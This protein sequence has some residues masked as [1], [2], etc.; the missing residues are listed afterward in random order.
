MFKMTHYAV[1][2]HKLQLLRFQIITVSYNL[3]VL[4][5]NGLCVGWCSCN[6]TSVTLP[7]ICYTADVDCVDCKSET[8]AW[9]LTADGNS[10]LCSGSTFTYSCYS[11]SGDGYLVLTHCFLLECLGTFTSWLLQKYTLSYETYGCFQV[12]VPEVWFGYK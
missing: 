11:Y 10:L 5:S 6:Y 7:T 3:M 1:S 4:W 8:D 9:L 2:A 12:I